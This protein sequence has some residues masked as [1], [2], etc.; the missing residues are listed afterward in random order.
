[1]QIGQ[2]FVDKHVAKKGSH[3]PAPY[4]SPHLANG[5]IMTPSRQAVQS[6]VR[7]SLPAVASQAGRAYVPPAAPNRVPTIANVEHLDPRVVQQMLLVDG[8]GLLVDLRGEDR[9]SG[10]IE[11]AVH[12]PA[13]DRVPF[14]TKIPDLVREWANHPMVVF[15]CQYSAHR[16]PQCANWYRAACSPQQRVAILA[17]GFRGWESLNLP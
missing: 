5:T 4:S 15:T 2:D 1:M 17:G 7:A 11:G 10:L 16:A 3:V 13:I 14:L 6:P 9:A 8:Y 12:V